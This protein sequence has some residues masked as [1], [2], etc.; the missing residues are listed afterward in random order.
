MYC[1]FGVK[2]KV[3]VVQN[4][5]M[6]VTDIVTDVMDE[7]VAVISTVI[8]VGTFIEMQLALML[9]IFNLHKAYN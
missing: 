3:D 1:S 2:S 5:L 7:R 8:Y 9:I 6:S 4:Y